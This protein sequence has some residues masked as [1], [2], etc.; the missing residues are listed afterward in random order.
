M[1]IRLILP[2]PVD[3]ATSEPHAPVD[4]V[5]RQLWFGDVPEGYDEGTC[6]QEFAHA[7]L[8]V[9]QRILVRAST[10]TAHGFY[11]MG[12]FRTVAEALSVKSTK[13]M[14]WSD[15]TEGPIRLLN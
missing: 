5:S 4:I 13:T 12:Y 11:G 8:P 1:K 15:G 14:R 7:G 10:G 9:P 3:Q 6:L 2:Q